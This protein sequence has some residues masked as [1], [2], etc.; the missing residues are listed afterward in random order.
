MA[1]SRPVRIVLVLFLFAGSALV[2][3]LTAQGAGGEPIR[4]AF[5]GPTTG[6]SAEDG[7]SAVRAIELVLDRVNAEGGVAGRPVVLDVYDDQNE[8][9]RARA[10]A[11]SI[12][13]ELHTVAVIGHNYSSC[14]IAAGEVYARGGLPA[15]AT[16][17][18]SL[19]VTRDNDWYFRTIFNDRAQGRLVTV[20]V[21]AVL[22]AER[23]AVVHETD[24]YGAFLAEVMEDW[25]PRA[26][27]S[28]AG[29]WF[30]DP[31]DP[32]LDVKLEQIA[33]EVVRE[34]GDGVLVLAM[35]PDAGVRLV[36]RLRDLAFAG[37]IVA[38]DALS[39]Q[40][41]VDG[42]RVYPEERAQP[43]YYTNGI[44]TVTPF[45]FDSG[46]R[47]AGTFMRQYV[48]RFDRSP[49]WY[50]AFAAD[51]AGVL[52]EA[53]RRAGL[54]PSPETIREDR[55]RLRQ[56]L[57]SIGEVDP[58][59]G[60]TGANF[61][62]AVGD[63]VK[64][65]PMGR[66]LNGEIVTALEQLQLAPAGRGGPELDPARLVSLAG[67]RRYRMDVAQVGVRARR[68][69]KPDFREGTFELDFD[70][71][72]RYRGEDAVENVEFT[73]AVE[74]IDLGEL[75]DEVV[76]GDL[77]YRLYRASGL[78]R[79]DS[80]DAG[81][82]EHVLAISFHHR[83]RTR[84]DL[85]FAIDAVG[86]NLGRARTRDQR[87]AR[88]NSLLDPSYG[89]ATTDLIFS[90]DSVD[91]NALGHPRYLDS[92]VPARSFSQL[93][94]GL[95]VKR[96]ALSLRGTVGEENRWLL[97]WIGVAGFAALFAVGRSR[98]PKLCWL[99]QSGFVLMVVIVA[100]PLLG[101][102]VGRHAGS[103][104][105]GVVGSVFDVLWWV[106]PATFVHIAIVRF[107]WQPAE[108]RSGHAVPTLLRA[109]V[110]SLVYLLA[111][112]GLV[113]FVY[114][115]RLTGLLATSGVLAMIIGLAVQLNITNIFA[116][117]AL[118]LERPFRV[119][120]WIMIHGRRPD[121]EDSV[122]G[123]VTDINWRTTRLV[124]AADTVV[125]V[126]NG[127]ISEKIITNF[128]HP[129][130]KS[131]FELE[132]TVDQS[133]SPDRVVAVIQAAVNAVV[134]PEAQGPMADPAPK[135]RIDSALENAVKYIVYYRLIPSQ[136]SPN[137]A[138]HTINESVLRHLREA[139]I[140]LAVPKRQIREVPP[141]RPAESLGEAE[142]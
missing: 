132:Y 32:Q 130:E 83:E 78:F 69:G 40:A 33:R 94:V 125:V 13:G 3:R 17:A 121:P 37:E 23:F 103:Y 79:T 93:T 9:K 58:V 126:P 91:E 5:A 134:G 52:I 10:N 88:A 21:R 19:A 56:A 6:P 75:V 108:E 141:V 18:T 139:D 61:F 72:F 43:G 138:R 106:V 137:Q 111:L 116:G 87:S 34:L 2:M 90:Q 11:P 127:V 101:D 36:K 112:F 22:G 29:S 50:A 60:V 89:W 107:I 114:D 64:P 28:R 133:V 98:M 39:S 48:G 131:R 55:A 84:Q 51:A 123:M 59:P 85:I 122:I 25:A 35:Q 74:P 82:G 128:S 67:E 66:F 115:Y 57:A 70:L 110:A 80:V 53:L 42:F 76:E 117:I 81:Y 77:R 96:Q 104:Y 27:L 41:F 109:F 129:D 135:V 102:W 7:L 92:G 47:V 113:A 63:V 31:A 140:E 105:E 120:D 38:T 99:L 73:N 20:Y 12:T 65:V 26:E 71:W 136:V 30:F 14:S 119:G 86:M 54:E 62:D 16:A 49:D 24:T 124:T 15:I 8:T 1:L 44:Y 142:Q 97:L 4:I 100:E 45:L 95:I 118:N 68:F 46:G